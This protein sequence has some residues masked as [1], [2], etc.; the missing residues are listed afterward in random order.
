MVLRTLILLFA[1]TAALAAQR[2]PDVQYEPTPPEVVAAM[3]DLGGVKAG[4]VLYDLGCGDG[5]IP[6]E[7]VRRGAR[8]VCVDIDIQRI[9]EAR[10]NARQAGVEERITFRHEDLMAT[11]LREATVV[12]LFL[13]ARLN[14]RLHP[15]LLKELRPGSRVVSHWHTM[16]RWKP[17]KTFTVKS[18]TREEHALFLWIVP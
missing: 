9:A 6:I 18:N 11:D 17:Q 1:V 12:T 16:S 2:V 8:G 14:D 13:S 5:R 15:K 4:D 10:V 7:A 3:L